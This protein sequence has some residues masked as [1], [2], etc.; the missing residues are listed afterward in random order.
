MFVA[1]IV[2]CVFS[3]LSL[4]MS[5]LTV[6]AAGRVSLDQRLLR[7]EIADRYGEMVDRTEELTGVVEGACDC[8]VSLD[9]KSSET[10][11]H[12]G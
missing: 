12:V 4:A 1:I 3:A 9:A 7:N 10:V 6:A 2:V 11:E 5:F 8:L